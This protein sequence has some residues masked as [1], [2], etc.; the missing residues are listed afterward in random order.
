[1][2]FKK[3]N[4]SGVYSLKKNKKG[5]KKKHDEENA[6]IAAKAL[7]KAHSLARCNHIDSVTGKRAFAKNDDGILVCKLCGQKIYTDRH[8][9]LNKD[10]IKTSAKFINSIFSF[11]KA[12]KSCPKDIIDELVIAEKWNMVAHKLDECITYSMNEEMGKRAKRKKKSKR[13]KNERKFNRLF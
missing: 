2:N 7:K 9:H 5:K 13:D 3:S 12:T 11:I 4:I 8:S 10:N 6:E 1:M